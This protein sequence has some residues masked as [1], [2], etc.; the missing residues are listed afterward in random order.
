LWL[1][2]AL[3][4]FGVAVNIIAAVNPH[5]CE[6]RYSKISKNY[7]AGHAAFRVSFMQALRR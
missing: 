4:W 7:Q 1:G 5:S 2:T 6:C 3:V